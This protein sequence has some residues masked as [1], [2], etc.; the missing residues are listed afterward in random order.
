MK[1]L[2]GR[3]KEGRKISDYFF[4]ERDRPGR[5]AGRLA[6]H[7]RTGA[8]QSQSKWIKPVRVKFGG[9]IV[10]KCFIMS[11]LQNKQPLGWSNSVKVHQ[12]GF[13][14]GFCSDLT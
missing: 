3:I 1:P 13:S 8:G 2:K 12:T 5:C 7:F 4:G 14:P 10:C 9:Q 6:P 11:G